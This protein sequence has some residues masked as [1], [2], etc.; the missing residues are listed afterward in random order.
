MLQG[1]MS[2]LQDWLALRA[3]WW[4][5]AY[6]EGGTIS[7]IEK[8]ATRDFVYAAQARLLHHKTYYGKYYLLSAV[9]II[10]AR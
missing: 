10:L 8:P 4:W 7:C 6:T 1:R 9:I 2:L 3:P 5:L